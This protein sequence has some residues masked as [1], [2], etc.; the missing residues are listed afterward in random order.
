[1]TI[2]PRR[3]ATVFSSSRSIAAPDVFVTAIVTETRKLRLAQSRRTVA[4][5]VARR[6]RLV[7]LTE[8]GRIAETGATTGLWIGTGVA[9][10]DALA[11]GCGGSVDGRAEPVGDDSG[12]PGRLAPALGLGPVAT[13]DPGPWPAT[14]RAMAAATT[15]PATTT[16]VIGSMRDRIGVIAEAYDPSGVRS[17]LDGLAAM[18]TPAA[19]DR[20]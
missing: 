2:P 3:A 19:P 4:L 6:F 14:P 18:A 1:M 20:S 10:G 15:S 12:G 17:T 8:P 13:S 11:V 9:V 7:R 16:T 5:Y